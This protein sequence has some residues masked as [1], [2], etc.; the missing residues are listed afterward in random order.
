[1]ITF[2]IGHVFTFTEIFISPHGFELLS[3]ILSFKKKLFIYFLRF[4]LFTF[5]ERGR[6]GGREGEELQC[7]V[8]SCVPQACALNGAW[9]SVLAFHL[10]ELP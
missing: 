7:V 10:A 5:R 4:Y 3:R 1:M 9:A 6:E 8:A 2:I